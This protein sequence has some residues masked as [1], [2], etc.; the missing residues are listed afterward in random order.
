MMLLNKF[1]KI[2]DI[3]YLLIPLLVA[4]E[5]A[6]GVLTYLSVGNH[7]ASEGNPLM[8]NIAATGNFLVMK[9]AGALLCALL[10]WLLYKRFPRVSLIS[11]SSI[12]LFYAFVFSWNLNILL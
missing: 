4:L 11:T 5:I 7:L 9:T 6:D 10:L 12:V 8:Q 2:Q 1:F 3:M